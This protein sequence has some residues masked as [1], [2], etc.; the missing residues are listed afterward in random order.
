MTA[1]CGNFNSGTPQQMYTALLEKIG[2]L[3][4]DTL[5]YCGHEYTEKNLLYAQVSSNSCRRLGQASSLL[6]HPCTRQRS[7][8][9]FY[10]LIFRVTISPLQSAEPDNTAIAEKLSW[11]RDTRAKGKPTVPSTISGGLRG[12]LP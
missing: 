4:F 11:V 7:M 12:S 9:P 2:S 5:I 3:P 10:S 8:L 1:G 6:P